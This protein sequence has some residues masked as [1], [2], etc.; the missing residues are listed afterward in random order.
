M[1]RQILLYRP[2]AERIRTWRLR[3]HDHAAKRA[4][5]TYA[6]YGQLKLTT[7]ADELTSTVALL[8]GAED[9]AELHAIRSAINAHLRGLGFE[10]PEA[11]GAGKTS[12][13]L[14]MFLRQHDLGFRIRRLRFLADRLTEMETG[15]GGSDEAALQAARDAIY[16][17]LAPFLDRQMRDHYEPPVVAAAQHFADDPATALASIAATRNLEALDTETDRAI[18]G[19]LPLLSKVDRRALLL[20]YLGF[21]FYDVATLSLIRLQGAQEFHAIQVDRISPDDCNSIRGGDASA[22]LKGVEFNRR[23]A[24]DRHPRLG[25][26]DGRD[27]R[28]G[29]RRDDQAIA[30]PRHSRRG[31]RRADDDPR[32]DRDDRRR[33]GYD[34][35]VLTPPNGWRTS[36][37]CIF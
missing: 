19:V 1:E 30:V 4:G 16:G 36:G 20:A 12:D 21:S 25:D 5:F 28:R 17:S 37:P 35:Q 31:T 34:G 27:D 10:E 23:R 24:D 29:G 6:G 7:I 18:A 11:L 3:S 22:T 8:I 14:V 13:A 32:A 15:A 26:P 9:A 33:G 2:S